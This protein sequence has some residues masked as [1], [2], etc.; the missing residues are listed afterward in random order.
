MT[1]PVLTSRAFITKGDVLRYTLLP[2]IVP[3]LKNLF[4]FGL[5][6][7]AA[8]IALVYSMVGLIPR[9]HPYLNPDNYGRFGVRQT[10]A[11]AA[12]NL[13]FEWRHADQVIMFFAVIA[14]IVIL[15]LQVILMLL[16]FSILPALAMPATPLEF[17]T[18]TYKLEDIAFI[19]LD[20]VF[21]IPAPGGGIGSFFGS[22]AGMGISCTD[23][24]GDLLAGST[25]SAFP[26][27]FQLALHGLLEFYNAGIFL[28]GVMIIIYLTMTV[29]GEMAQ[30]GTPFGRR[31]NRVWAPTRLILF[32]FLILP[33]V[34]GL[35]ICQMAVMHTAYFGSSM[36]T[37]GWLLFNQ[38]LLS[39]TIFGAEKAGPVTSGTSIFGQFELDGTA[40]PSAVSNLVAIP[41]T[42]DPGPLLQFYNTVHT[43]KYAE[44]ILHNRY[45][46][47]YLVRPR[48]NSTTGERARYVNKY[49]N[50]DVV[51]GPEPGGGTFTGF[52]DGL[53]FF[54]DGDFVI[55]F[56]EYNPDLYPNE[57]GFVFPY[58]GE[59]TLVNPGVTTVGPNE[60][61]VYTMFAFWYSL[62]GMVLW[63]SPT[64]HDWGS[65][66]ARTVVGG[67]NNLSLPDT[68]AR[69]AM[70]DWYKT[71]MGLG[72]DLAVAAQVAAIQ[73]DYMIPADILNKGWAGAGIWYNRI[74]KMNGSLVDAVFNTPRPKLWPDALE[75]ILNAKRKKDSNVWGSQRFDPTLSDTLT[76][77]FRKPQE[78]D[79]ARAENLTF[80]LWE[81]D[82]SAAAISQGTLGMGTLL[83]YLGVE[84][85]VKGTEPVTGNAVIDSINTLLGTSGLFNMR[86]N[87][88]THPLAQLVAVGRAM[89]NSAIV[90]FGYA[91]GAVIGGGIGTM[92]QLWSGELAK[93]ATGFAFMI[94][95]TGLMIG[96]ML[97]YVIPFLPFVYFFFAVGG[98][99]KAIFEAMVGVPLWAL[100]HL[101]ID[102]DGLPGKMGMSGYFLL[103]EIFVRP[104]LTIFGL[105]GGIIILTAMV[106][107]LN[108]LWDI[109][110]LNL[111]GHD[112]SQDPGALSSLVGNTHATLIRN[113]IDEFMFTIMYA[114]VVYMMAMSSFKLIDM[115]PNQILRWLGAS[116]STFGEKLQDPG[117]QLV[118]MTYRG[119]L[120]MSTGFGRFGASGQT[121]FHSMFV[122]GNK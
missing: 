40:D 26:T 46:Q 119:G 78:A 108:E 79:I 53:S 85:D 51:V 55:R 97:F 10:I 20:R 17:F 57:T 112:A 49:P 60:P 100:A 28:V 88:N 47:A 96:F 72:I 37:N 13:R 9:G 19:L 111:S 30:S 62:L 118:G 103:F 4:T 36:A 95:S 70:V 68:G 74:A 50:D 7:F 82:G 23:P 18:T 73:T 2:G 67:E 94:A 14:G 75:Q 87:V 45:V 121:V 39:P 99:I 115:V 35:N 109:V 24:E 81:R 58:C 25:M 21:G 65:N 6:Y 106:R 110:I 117:A 32:F 33:V 89:I 3:R 92:L 16:S 27:P 5:D 122:G 29:A 34:Y 12:N 69:T 1:A 113:A 63:S 77:K 43:C 105:I 80:Q 11:V 98:W 71:T 54:E 91:A 8:L 41:N 116:V 66:T 31:F 48:P 84:P 56:G 104:I 114:I 93:A 44:R 59:L 22:C 107:S 61:G 90:N 38:A 15:V 120:S 52:N 83:S 42:P 64:L 86:E 101:R 102:G 76:V